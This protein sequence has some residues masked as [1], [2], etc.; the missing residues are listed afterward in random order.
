MK[1]L[2]SEFPIAFLNIK[3]L[4]RLVWKQ[5][6]WVQL[7]TKVCNDP[8]Y[9]PEHPTPPPPPPQHTHTH[10]P[11]LNK[12]KDLMINHTILR[13]LSSI[14]KYRLWYFYVLQSLGTKKLW[15]AWFSGDW[16]S[17]KLDCLTSDCRASTR[18]KWNAYLRLKSRE[19]IQ[20]QNLRCGIILI[21]GQISDNQR[22]WSNLCLLYPVSTNLSQL[23]EVTWASLMKEQ[24]SGQSL[25]NKYYSKA[26]CLRMCEDCILTFLENKLKLGLSEPIYR[27]DCFIFKQWHYQKFR[28]M[29]YELSKFK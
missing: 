1:F 29:R 5:T 23:L 19:E 8:L 2:C 18:I 21:P 27:A 15:A 6:L 11:L 17:P 3:Q 10:T 13:K 26:T 14:W 4:H 28:A 25:H 22:E 9:T 12:N 20:F 16:W 24:W 7:G